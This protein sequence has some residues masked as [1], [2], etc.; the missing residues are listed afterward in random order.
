MAAASSEYFSL[1]VDFKLDAWESGSALVTHERYL[2][3]TDEAV[4]AT[5]SPMSPLVVAALMASPAIFARET[6]DGDTKQFARV[7]RITDIDSRERGYF[8]RFDFDPSVP[9]IPQALFAWGLRDELDIRGGE[10]NRTH[11]AVKKGD[12]YDVLRRHSLIK[13]PTKLRTRRVDTASPH[14]IELV[15]LPEDLVRLGK[16]IPERTD[17]PGRRV[18]IVHGHAKDTKHEVEAFLMRLGL[19]PVILDQVAGA[20]KTII[21]KFEQEAEQ[22][23]FAVVLLT[24]DDHGAAKGASDLNPR[25]R[26]NVIFELGYFAGKLGRGRVAALKRGDVEIPSDYNGVE[27]IAFDD[28]GGWKLNLAR[29][30]KHAGL[31]VDPSRIV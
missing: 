21:E 22:A 2:E 30:M 25:A 6:V 23:V 20:S 11:W 28:H 4:A 19:E 13:R 1:L 26:Q 12:L 3:H 5:F 15:P 7:G 8:I 10:M 18:F 9:P 27:Y 14:E 17:A 24:P 31:P 29:H 16:A